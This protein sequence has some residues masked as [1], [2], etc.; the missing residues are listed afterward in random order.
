MADVATLIANQTAAVNATMLQVQAYLDALVGASAI[1][2]GAIPFSVD[3]VL[4]NDYAYPNIPQ[5]PDSV[6]GIPLVTAIP[7]DV[8][9]LTFPLSPNIDVSDIADIDLLS[10]PDIVFP[11]DNLLA[12]DD[13]YQFAE[14]VYVSTL[15]NPLKAKLLDNLINGG[16]GIETN[17][18]VALFNRERDREVQAALTR[19]DDAGRA[20]AARGFPLPPGELAI[21]I[22]RAYQDMQDKVSTVSR[23][24]ALTRSKLYVENRQFTIREVR[25]LEQVLMNYWN[26]VQE[27]ALNMA[28][29]TAEFAITVYNA[30]L[31]KYRVEFEGAKAQADVQVQRV[32]IRVEAARIKIM[33]FQAL[34]ASFEAVLRSIIE[35]ARLKVDMYR[36]DIEFNKADIGRA[37][38]NS[39]I[40]LG[41]FTAAWRA[42]TAQE[43]V[44]VENAKVKLEAAIQA[45]K[46]RADAA[47]FGADKFFGLLTSMEST[48]NT[49]AVQSTTS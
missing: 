31:A 44:A 34:I 18:E 6:G 47:K 22:D 2:F 46:F 19:I 14:A 36:A 17:D 16:Y 15:L 9:K 25:E 35:P 33:R 45:L 24:I 12:P 23:D 49:L 48:V 29:A 13:T 20:M 37:V 8:T 11:L 7:L 38:S 3:R 43:Q 4:T 42:G 5:I 1:N 26:S 30:T 10:F 27:R 40:Q 28:R 41:A 21:N 32:Q 39:E